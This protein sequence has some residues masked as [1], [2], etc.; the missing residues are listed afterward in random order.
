MWGYEDSSALQWGGSTECSH[1]RRGWGVT[2]HVILSFLKHCPC[3]DTQTGSSVRLAQND[4]GWF[5]GPEIL[6]RKIHHPSLSNAI[7]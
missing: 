7:P 3:S 5:L 4:T 6:D 2:L 1:T